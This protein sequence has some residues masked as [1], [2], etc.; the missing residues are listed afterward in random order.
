M[1]T[2]ET[3]TGE[4]YEVVNLAAIYH[5]E[6][7]LGFQHQEDGNSLWVPLGGKKESG[8]ND[9]TCLLRELTAGTKNNVRML[10]ENIELFGAF[11][12]KTPKGNTSFLAT[13]YMKRMEKILQ[14]NS[15]ISLI[16]SFSFGAALRESHISE[17]TRQIATALYQK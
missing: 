11:I 12:G 9:Y 1:N 10:M 7:L 2:Y 15:A 4:K 17:T 5:N 16:Q 13:V 8:E 6:L 14:P 3:N